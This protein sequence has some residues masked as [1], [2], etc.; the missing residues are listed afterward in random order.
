MKKEPAMPGLTVPVPGS[1]SDT[2]VG[3]KK[4]KKTLTISSHFIVSCSR[5]LNSAYHAPFN[6][7]AS[8][9]AQFV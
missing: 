7:A 6:C 3:E 1:S 8:R 5:S 2:G 9:R 4:V